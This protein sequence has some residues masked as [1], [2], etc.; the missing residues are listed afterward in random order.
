M[1][2]ILQRWQSSFYL[3]LL[4]LALP[5]TLQTLMFSS[6]GMI[7]SMML[8][9]LGATEIA[10][11]GI[12][13]KILFVVTIF[14]LGLAMGAG[15]LAAQAWGARQAGLTGAD[16]LPR[17]L[18]QGLWLQWLFTLPLVALMVFC[19]AWLIGLVSPE[20]ALL[21]EGGAF[22]QI[23][24]PSLL[25]FN[26]TCT[27]CSG[28]RAMQQPG[29]ATLYSVIG[30]LVNIVLN[31][32]LIFGGWGI[33]ALGVKGAALGTALG[34]VVEASLLYLHLRWHG[35]LLAR[36][37]LWQ[38]PD[39]A[40][41]RT[42]LQLSLQLATNSTLWAL[43]AL[44][45][46]AI[47]GGQ[48]PVTLA[49]LSILAPIESFSLA[50]LI[51]LSCAAAILIGA[52]VGAGDEALAQQQ[53]WAALW[54]GLVLGLVTM[55]AVGLAWPLLLA[56]YPALAEPVVAELEILFQLMLLGFVVKS[57]AMM[58]LAGVLRGGGDNG[59]C[60]GLDFSVQWLLIIPLA[61]WLSVALHW[62]ASWLYALML[63]EELLKIGG[64]VARMS[65]G[66]WLHRLVAA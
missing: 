13:T 15:Q 2:F 25:L 63:L 65:S 48:N 12:A 5:I 44:V 23:V 34:G 10:A 59:F 32:W 58:L 40:A 46:F 49:A 3:R 26:Y 53:G 47:V 64:A 41:L 37:P 8:G 30:V 20:A 9:R 22:L 6:K 29:I 56:Q 61:W 18:A 7:D 19:P 36:L 17:Q 66:R 45:F 43:G 54:L 1:T 16:E 14:L 31:A 24:G 55:L 62:P 27:L 33:E 11:V 52:T 35:H 50:L 42:Q 60:L 51:G 38:W 21:H 4:S 39:W 57:C 28:L